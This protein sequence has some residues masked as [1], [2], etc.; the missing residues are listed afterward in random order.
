ME[1]TLELTAQ[2]IV[3]YYGQVA[4]KRKT[5]AQNEKMK[6]SAGY[7]MSLMTSYDKSARPKRG[8]NGI[9]TRSAFRNHRLANQKRAWE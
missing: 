1:R 8:G 3:H 9:E 7:Q 5:H 6:K 2:S 4:H